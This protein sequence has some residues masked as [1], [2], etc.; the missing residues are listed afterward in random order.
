MRL[1]DATQ[2][3]SGEARFDLTLSL[4]DT[5][6]SRL[7]RTGATGESPPEIVPGE[8]A[9]L[10][11]LAPDGHACAGLGRSGRDVDAE[12]ASRQGGQP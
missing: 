3:K 7:A 12:G 2:G 10:A 8:A 11:R 4:L 9:T 5:A 6:L 1:A